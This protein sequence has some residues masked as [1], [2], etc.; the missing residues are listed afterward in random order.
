MAAL[1]GPFVQC[2]IGAT[3]GQ[4]GPGLDP[5]E[6]YPARRYL[7]QL[8]RRLGLDPGFHQEPGPG[9]TPVYFHRIRIGIEHGDGQAVRRFAIREVAARFIGQFRQ[10]GVVAAM[11]Q[12]GIGVG[13]AHAFRDFHRVE[14]APPGVYRH[15]GENEGEQKGEE[16]LEEHG[17]DLGE[18]GVRRYYIWCFGRL[19]IIQP[20]ALREYL[21]RSVLVALFLLLPLSSFAAAYPPVGVRVGAEQIAP[22]TYYIPGLPGAASRQNQGFMSNAGFVV[23]PA[24]VVVFDTLGSPSLAAEMLKRIREITTVPVRRVIVS[25][26]HADHYYGIQVFKDAGAEVWAH[27][28]GRNVVGSE[29]WR[30][31]LEQRYDLL[32]EWIN[33]ETQRF[34]APDRWLEGDEDFELGGM[35]FQVRHVGPAHSPEDLVLFVKED[36]VLFTGDLI[37]KGRVPFI[38][39]ADSKRWLAALERLIDL[40]PR[41]M[42]PGHGGASDDPIGDLTFTRDYLLYLREQM[43]RAVADLQ[44]F[45]EAYEKTDW[46]RYEKMPAYREAHRRNAYNTFLLMERESLK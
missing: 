34:P 40:K 4:Q 42:A 43:G 19:S 39:D 17:P 29:D 22:H 1:L 7:V 24:G 6:H 31:R 33:A 15:Q 41:V 8:E 30:L 14:A 23:T 28:E 5:D 3:R 18:K 26:Y 13:A 44:S 25:H 35:H 38:G 16:F 37:F 32:G 2:G 11:F 12:I 21:M 27:R 46:S 10:F 20:P 9:V 45:E 36:G